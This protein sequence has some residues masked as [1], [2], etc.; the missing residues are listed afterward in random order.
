MN[1]DRPKLTELLGV[2]LKLGFVAFGGPAAHIAL[3]EDE[4]V[5]RKRWLDRDH[6]MDLLGATNLIPGP[7][8][9]EMVI[10][11]GYI[12]RGWQG[13]VLAG[14]C[15]I[16]PAA[17]MTVVI[18]YFY[19]IYGELPRM[20]P[21]LAGIKA[22]VIA[23][24]LSALIRLARTAI[25]GPSLAVLAALVGL[26]AFGGGHEVWLILGGG[27]VGMCWLKLRELRPKV[28]PM[29]LAPLSGLTL[30]EGTGILN[31]PSLWQIALFFSKVGSVLFGSGYVL[32]AFLQGGLVRDYGWLSE[33]Q[34]LD[35]VAA[36]QLTPGPVLTTATFVGYLLHSWSG[37]LVA[38]CAIFLPSYLFVLILNPLIPRL[39]K[40]SWSAAFMDAVNA[41][42]VALMAAVLFEL[43]R[44][45]LVDWSGWL[46]AVAA[47]VLILNYKI[48]GPYLVVL[49][50]GLGYLFS[51][52]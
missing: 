47:L 38:T 24:I 42:A 15:F 25:K 17:A 9:T 18:A 6:F 21:F 37:A 4:I 36:G 22:V 30:G 1:G 32:I 39:R 19:E 48:S 52:L 43:S 11:I 8:S 14:V 35:A 27:F 13:M 46:I 41:S 51:L 44:A 31:Q 7:N 2:F 49:G 5:S 10:H 50:A 33:Q 40:S 3:F 28:L 12:A 45:T 20:A 16:L 34:L 23:I 26:L 29:L